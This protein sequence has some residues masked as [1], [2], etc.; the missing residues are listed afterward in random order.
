MR[1]PS[2]YVETSIWSQL[3][4]DD[5]PHMR[6]ATEDF[7]VEAGRG[8]FNLF[9]SQVVFEEIARAS[10]ETTKQL[11][12]LIETYKPVFL[13][14]TEEAWSLAEE[15]LRNGA[16]PPSKVDDA[17]H[18]AVAVANELD[19]LL[20]WNYKHLVNMRRRELFHY[21]SVVNGY[22]KQLQILTPLE[23]PDESE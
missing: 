6:E 9:V 8:K 14:F 23:V 18:V 7:L 17:R 19:I 5:A 13:D 22:Y 4:T 16:V 2:I 20:S 15:F 3:T 1:K 21:I 11:Q 12:S 10:E